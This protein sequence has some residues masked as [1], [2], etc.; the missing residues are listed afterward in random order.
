M[1]VCVTCIKNTS[2]NSYCIHCLLVLIRS[3]CCRLTVSRIQC[4]T[5]FCALFPLI[6]ALSTVVRSC[7]GVTRGNITL[8]KPSLHKLQMEGNMWALSSH[9]SWVV[10]SNQ[11][12]WYCLSGLLHILAMSVWVE[13]R[14]PGL[15][16]LNEWINVVYVNPELFATT[17]VYS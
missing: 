12:S 13:L 3:C 4:Y 8:V 9:S 16:T 2:E 14:L 15:T 6:G 17:W 10:G 11:S 5:F 7:L 1:S